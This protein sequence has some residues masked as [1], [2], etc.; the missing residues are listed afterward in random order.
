MTFLLLGRLILTPHIPHHHT[1]QFSY[2]SVPIRA[3]LFSAQSF[4]SPHRQLSSASHSY[5]VRSCPVRVTSIHYLDNCPLLIFSFHSTYWFSRVRILGGNSLKGFF[6]SVC[7]LTCTIWEVPKLLVVGSIYG[8]PVFINHNHDFS[9]W[10][11][12]RCLK[13]LWSQEKDATSHDS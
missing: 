6:S 12:F 3:Q 4:L 5:H 1:K 2:A 7:A 13:K 8:K 9:P 10:I 11:I